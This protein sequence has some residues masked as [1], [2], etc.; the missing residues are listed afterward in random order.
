[1]RSPSA[2]MV[3]G[4]TVTEPSDGD[5]DHEDRAERERLKDRMA[6]HPHPRHRDH[7]G[8][9]GDQHGS[10]RGRGGDLEGLFVAAS[11]GAL[12][13]LA[14]DV[15]H[16]VIDTDG[17]PDEQDDRADRLGHGHQMAHRAEDPD[18]RNRRRQPQQQRQPRSDQ[19]PERR[20]E[21]QQR[22]RQREDL[23]AAGIVLECL[24]HR[25]ARTG[26]AE[27]LD[28]ERRDATP[29]RPPSHRAP[30]RRGHGRPWSRRE[31]RS[32]RAPNGRRAEIRLA[33][34]ERGKLT[35]STYSKR[36]S[37]RPTSSTGR[38][39]AGPGPAPSPDS[40]PR[41]APWRGRRSRQR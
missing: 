11:S 31:R 1:M 10:T 22:D 23:G 4:T 12:V 29:A 28:P 9:A 17:E 24:S 18:R 20:H 8:Q 40:A 39:S 19:R 38:G 27:L 32:A 21:D 26:G 15:E 16:R 33:S 37:A 3:A 36:V 34:V 6:D 13:T 30:A 35:F 5:R 41:P 7:H 14:A 25:L 2:A